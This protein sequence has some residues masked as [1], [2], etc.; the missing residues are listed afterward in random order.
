M[1]ELITRASV[2]QAL[3]R[4]CGSSAGAHVGELAREIV[5]AQVD[6]GTERYLR[7]VIEELRLE[8]HH[9]CGTPKHGYF[10]AAT[11]EE[12]EAT[13]KFLYDR[14]MSSLTQVSRMKKIAL[15]D[16][17]GQLHIKT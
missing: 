16:L 11:A 3:G 13:C 12:L 17:A 15:P 8:G 2:L 7:A 14:A 5:H 4:H 1:R 10:I 9:I 6:A